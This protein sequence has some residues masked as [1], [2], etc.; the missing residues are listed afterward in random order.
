MAAFAGIVLMQTHLTLPRHQTCI[1]HSLQHKA[2]DFHSMY[3]H[4]QNL[5]TFVSWHLQAALGTESAA[6]RTRLSSKGSPTKESALEAKRASQAE[7]LDHDVK[8]VMNYADEKV[9]HDALF[10]H[11]SL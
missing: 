7:A 2:L 4:S 11:V 10:L 8:Q 5:S 9:H 1:L 6:K 3:R